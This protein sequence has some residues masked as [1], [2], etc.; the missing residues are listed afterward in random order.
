MQLSKLVI[1]YDVPR[2]R[3]TPIIS[4]GVVC[5]YRYAC[6]LAVHVRFLKRVVFPSD[7]SPSVVFSFSFYI[8]KVRKLQI[9]DNFIATTSLEATAYDVTCAAQGSHDSW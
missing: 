7:P 9:K 5:A 8:T 2:G 6:C 4:Q 1:P 3:R